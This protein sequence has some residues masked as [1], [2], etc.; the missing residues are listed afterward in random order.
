MTSLAHLRTCNQQVSSIMS[1]WMQIERGT[2]FPTGQRKDG[3]ITNKILV[4]CLETEE[5]RVL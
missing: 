5:H 2:L 3:I 1:P 4:K